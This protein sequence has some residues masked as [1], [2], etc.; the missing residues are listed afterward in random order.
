MKKIIYAAIVAAISLT[1]I[2][3][4]ASAD[5]KSLVIIDSYFDL[6]KL[7]TSAK[8]ICVVADGCVSN[9]TPSKAVSDAANHG[10]AM[11]EIALKQNPSLNLIVIRAS[12]VSKFGSIS[13]VN[14]NTLL[15]ALKWVEQNNALV[16]AVSFSYSLSGN[17][18]KLGECKLSATGLTNVTLVDPQIRSSIASLKS[19]GIPFFAATGNNGPSKPVSYPACIV[20]TVSVG[21]GVGGSYIPASSRDSYTDVIGS[22]PANKFSYKSNVF[23]QIPQTTS[24]ATAGVAAKYLSEKLDKGIVFVIP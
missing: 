13:G 6:S 14:G 11:A 21:S 8:Q 15:S 2:P 18:T 10:T 1:A 3:T 5:S 17:M 24:S 4:Q 20:D 9:A 22:L 12:Q 19:A 23:G 16:G 7:P